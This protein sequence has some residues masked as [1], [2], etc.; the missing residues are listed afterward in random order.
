V[1]ITTRQADSTLNHQ[2]YVLV[3]VIPKKGDALF[4]R[5]VSEVLTDEV[6]LKE[7]SGRALNR[8]EV[9]AVLGGKA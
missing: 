5:Q 8:I 9:V 3:N 2:G 7:M 1:G 4:G 6:L